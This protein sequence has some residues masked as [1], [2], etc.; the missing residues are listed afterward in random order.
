MLLLSENLTL[1]E[2]G[3]REREGEGEGEGGRERERLSWELLMDSLRMML[4]EMGSK[5]DEHSF[6]SSV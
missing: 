1:A 4:S 5:D 2:R 6:S 3:E